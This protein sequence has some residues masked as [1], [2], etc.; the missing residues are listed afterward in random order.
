MADT[1]PNLIIVT[2]S[3]MRRDMLGCYGNNLIRTPNIDRLAR[4]GTVFS[5]CY[6]AS[7]ARGCAQVSF[8]TG[9]SPS[10]H[11]R[12]ADD[13]KVSDA[14]PSLPLILREQGYRCALYGRNPC[15]SDTLIDACF[16]EYD[17]AEKPLP[18][19]PNAWEFAEIPADHPANR[20]RDLTRAA[21]EFIV[22]SR[23][24][25]FFVWLVLD[26]CSA[27]YAIPASHSGAYSPHSIELPAAFARP[28][29]LKFEPRRN[30]IWRQ[31]SR[32]NG[33]DEA[34]VRM[35]HVRA[36]CAT[37]LIDE[38]MGTLMGMLEDRRLV[39]ETLVALCGDVGD[40][41][42]Y[43]G[44][45]Q[46][47]PVF[48]DGLMRIP[49][50][51]RPPRKLWKLPRFESLV[52]QS[53]LAPT[54][55]DSM[56]GSVP[57]SMTGRSLLSCLKAGGAAF[58]DTALAIGGT[59]SHVAGHDPSR[60]LSQPDA[61][62]W[63]GPGAMLRK[64]DYKICMYADDLPELYD[65]E[66]DP[67]ELKN[68]WN[69][70]AFID[71]REEMLR[72]LVIRQL[73]TKVRKFWIGDPRQKKPD[74]RANAPESPLVEA[75]RYP[76]NRRIPR[77]ISYTPAAASAYSSRTPFG[78]ATPF[79][80]RRLQQVLFIGTANNFRCRF[81]EA[82]FNYYADLLNLRETATS[83][84]VYAESFTG[85]LP[86]ITQD[87]AKE[88]GIPLGY[89]HMERRQLTPEDLERAQTVIC[90]SEAEHRIMLEERFPTWAD[91]VTYWDANDPEF[92]PPEETLAKLEG[93]IFK[94]LAS[95]ASA[96]P[97]NAPDDKAE[98]APAAAAR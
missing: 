32:A 30:E 11:Q 23:G 17:I 35:H 80:K 86:Q 87:A 67:H 79:S 50:I 42:G 4:E 46:R 61:A 89:I 70:P 56:V 26:D 22:N 57:E 21:A 55:L 78:S 71:V 10:E 69:D 81:A 98:K 85:P 43:R 20:T 58:R 44:M 37:G 75:S 7:P 38:A 96:Q 93:S 29:V 45:F 47:L 12:L 9:T 84:G 95:L 36:M 88:H 77:T 28:G 48:Y 97:A 82:Y 62:T 1:P 33:A 13:A 83:R 6:A 14:L 90:M 41:L 24:Q 94:L 51:I 27:P 19:A 34:A 16:D 40:L 73:G 49:A 5:H 72:E 92:E 63:Q 54:L 91:R 59:G 64:G 66:T 65:V 52:E 76:R 74:P 2:P 31:H 39:D 53:D 68:L 18:V 8:A 15:F 60:R 25:P 3:C